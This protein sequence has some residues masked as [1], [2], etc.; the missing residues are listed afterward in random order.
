MLKKIFFFYQNNFTCQRFSFLEKGGV[1]LPSPLRTS[2]KYQKK[3]NSGLSGYYNAIDPS[4]LIDPL[5]ANYN[6]A[7]A[8]FLRKQSAASL[9]FDVS[10]P[11]IKPLVI[12]YNNFFILK[13]SFSFLKHKLFISK[14]LA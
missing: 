14:L 4:F 6:R 7:F 5:S 10:I 11:K 12:V 9:L 8:I 2:F 13:T 1:P 3:T